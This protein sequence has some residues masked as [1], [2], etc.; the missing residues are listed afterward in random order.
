M[1][2]SNLLLGLGVWV[3]LAT[4]KERF[5]YADGDDQQTEEHKREA[6]KLYQPI[7]NTNLQRFLKENPDA[8]PFEPPIAA[9]AT[10]Y[11]I[12][13]VPKN[14][15]VFVFCCTFRDIFRPDRLR[16]S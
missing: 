11:V 14:Y 3:L 5:S 10:H 8:K 4:Y 15:K 2:K 7:Q 13:E 9:Q 1:R 16:A 6:R 12:G